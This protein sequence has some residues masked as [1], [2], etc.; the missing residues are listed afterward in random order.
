[1]RNVLLIPI[2][3]L[4]LTNNFGQQQRQKNVSET[5]NSA[6]RITDYRLP[7]DKLE[8]SRALYL[9]ETR[10]ALFGT[11][12]S[13]AIMCAFLHWRW[14][15]KIRN[16]AERISTK[17]FVQAWIVLPLFAVIFFVLLL[18]L[19]IY[20]HQIR[21]RFGLSVQ[22]WASWFRDQGVE[23]LLMCAIGSVLVW[24]LYAVIRRWPRR[25]WFYFWLAV[26]P[27]SA[28]LTF[29]APVA[30]DP[31]FDKFQPL[32]N[33][34]PKL[35]SALEEAA[36]RGGLDIPRS[37]MFEMKASEKVT[38]SNAYVTGFGA[39]KRVVV[40]DTA[41][42]K[43][44]TPELVYVFSHEMG[45]YVLQHV[46]K[47]F[48]FGIAV[49]FV[50]FYVS[51]RLASWAQKRWGAEWGIRDLSDWA[52]LPMLLLVVSV[53]FFL[54]TP[55]LNAF[56]RHIEHQADQFGLEVIHGLIPDSPEVAARS[57]QALGEEWLDYPYP[58]KWAVWWFWDHPT[59]NDRVR[60]ALTYDPWSE[61]R[62][63]EVVK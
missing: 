1:M 19:R 16:L 15:A 37:R 8:K 59:I 55:G 17:R 58:S 44:P 40:W 52:S 23:L 27:I 25:A 21:L 61:G 28:F 51:Y 56:S 36:H 2:L 47:G 9:I 43:M 57:F 10:V 49:F 29:I 62:S 24:I 45:H 5:A 41:I 26:I 6:E 12:Y 34:H 50:I 30:I 48:I 42:Q 4:L 46:L 54:I 18:P 39:T 53:L 7:P 3:F 13:F 63:P 14:M 33:T 22:G 20:G 31:L 32:E 60:F 38:G 35:V 11:A